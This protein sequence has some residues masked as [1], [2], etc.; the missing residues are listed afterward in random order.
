[1]QGKV[2]EEEVDC[3]N[4]PFYYPSPSELKAL[5]EANGA[6]RIEGMAELGAAMRSNPDPRTVTA[7]LRAVIGVLV[8]ERFGAGMADDLF[9]LHLE[10]LLKRPI[11]DDTHQKETVY[12]LFLKRKL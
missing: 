7:H 11:V 1:M 12:F 8:E 4:L 6:F 9:E 10:K 2:S 5:I 3:F